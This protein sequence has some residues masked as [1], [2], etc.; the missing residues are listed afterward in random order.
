MS[1]GVDIWLLL[2]MHSAHSHTLRTAS[3]G[4]IRNGPSPAN[5]PCSRPGPSGDMD[6]VSRGW[7]RW[8]TVASA[9]AVVGLLASGGAALRCQAFVFPVSVGIAAGQEVMP[10]TAPLMTMMPGFVS[11]DMVL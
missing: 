10:L 2:I 5:W 11:S 6:G 1:G 4:R 8:I 7:M 9:E 3:V